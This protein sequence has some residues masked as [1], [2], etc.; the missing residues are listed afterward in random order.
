MEARACTQRL[1]R[2]E[3]QPGA[4]DVADDSSR[5]RESFE[6][7]GIAILIAQAQRELQCAGEQLRLRLARRD[8]R[9]SDLVERDALSELV[10]GTRS[11][12]SREAVTVD[13]PGVIATDMTSGVKE[14]YD[15]LIA[16]GLT[17]E[18]R[19]GTPEDVGRAVAV[20]AKGELT[21]A[22]GQ[23]LKID[24]GLTLARL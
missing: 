1:S 10:A 16:G 22:T 23:V 20:L 15:N 2:T 8:A 4:L 9:P 3:K 18:Q 14:K 5:S 19:W 17:V 24:G 21:Y 11:D 13:G 6:R 7:V 12:L